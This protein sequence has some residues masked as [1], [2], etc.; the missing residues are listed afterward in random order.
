MRIGQGFPCA[1]HQG[2][3]PH[4]LKQR[5]LWVIQTLRNLDAHRHCSAED[6]QSLKQGDARFGLQAGT[7]H[8]QANRIGQ[9][10][11]QVVQAAR[12]QR[13]G[14][15]LPRGAHHHYEGRA[16]IAI[17]STRR[18]F[19]SSANT[20]MALPQPQ[21][22]DISVPQ[23]KN[24]AIKGRGPPP[25]HYIMPAQAKRTR[26]RSPA[27]CKAAPATTGAQLTRRSRAQA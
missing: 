5:R 15:A 13:G 11:A 4:A 7:D 26:K 9:R 22:S 25:P 18:C 10:T 17:V 14:S 6:Q 2:G 12:Q 3:Q 1:S 19:A 27:P 24:H 21:H 16:L 23:I 8:R 20:S